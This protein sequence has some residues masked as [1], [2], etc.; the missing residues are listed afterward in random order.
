MTT[1]KFIFVLSGV[2]SG[3]GKG[4][5]CSVIGA[6]LKTAGYKVNIKK[7]DPYLNVDPGTLN[8]LEHGE[9]FVSKDGTESDLDLGHYKRFADINTS[10]TNSTS[11]GKLLQKLLN[12]ER[13]GEF[14]GFTVQ[15]TPHFTNIIRNFIEEKKVNYDFIIV[16]V[17]GNVGDLESSFFLET[18]RQMIVY[19][20]K[21]KIIIIALTYLLYL[22]S[23]NE[24]KTKPTQQAIKTFLLHGLQPDILLCRTEKQMNIKIK[25]KLSLYTNININNIIEAID[26]DN[27]YYL[28]ILYNNKG[29]ISSILNHFKLENNT[30]KLTNWIDL[31]NKINNCKKIIKIGIVGKYVEL[32]D[33]YYS[34]I[35]SLKHA[36]WAYNVQI[37]I[38][39]INARVIKNI[40]NKLKNVDAVI[41][42][43]GF[44]KSGTDQMINAINYCRINK[45][46]FLG[47]CLGMQL[48]IIEF[49]KNVLNIKNPNS[50][51]LSKFHD[52]ILVI[53]LMEKW[54]DNN[55]F[56]VRKTLGNKNGTGR[57]GE[58][59][60]QLK[61][62]SFVHKLYNN[63][64]KIFKIF[65]DRY[66]MDPHFIQQFQKKN[67]I[68]S[69]LCLNNKIPLIFEFNDHPF[70][71]GVQ[72]HPEFSSTPFNPEPIFLGLIKSCI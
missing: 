10:S 31:N 35:E 29:L 56:E 7:L 36:G 64:N 6:I 65:R 18:I 61:Q 51:E 9:V 69:G 57:V 12:K 58:F 72:Y 30:I 60:I 40:N 17:G 44:D 54:T 67:M 27:L 49:A 39:W 45:I 68:I 19:H 71:I 53:K 11:S 2:I 8:P 42:P 63:S 55:N 46:P 25:T 1:T 33:A 41:V 47:I 16:E 4:I 3:I 66:D 13:N 37:N 59:C 32:E 5:T 48:A 34:L 38:T 22:K 23:T 15:F 20:G 70:F 43:G 28:P 62:N 21:E 24:L 26:V 52:D 14:L 50:Q